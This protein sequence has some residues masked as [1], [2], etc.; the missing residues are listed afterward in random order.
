MG[1]LLKQLFCLIFFLSITPS[2]AVD[3]IDKKLQE[4]L[5]RSGPGETFR[6]LVI[7]QE[8]LDIQSYDMGLTETNAPL[9]YRHQ[10]IV[11]ALQGLAENSQGEI[12]RQIEEFE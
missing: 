7:M 11:E 1:Y 9:E 8:Q 6:V 10:V 5:N 12:L 4:K 3:T 2:F